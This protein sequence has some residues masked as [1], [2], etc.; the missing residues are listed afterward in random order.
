MS[1]LQAEM[2]ALHSAL[3]NLN[4]EKEKLIANTRQVIAMTEEFIERLQKEHPESVGVIAP[5]LEQLRA[6]MAS[7]GQ[8]EN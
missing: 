6:T 8:T 4:Q 3:A 7:L 1:T 5:M 2:Q